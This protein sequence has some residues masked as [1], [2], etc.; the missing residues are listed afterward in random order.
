[1]ICYKGHVRNENHVPTPVCAPEQ[2]TL[3]VILDRLGKVQALPAQAPLYWRALALLSRMALILADHSVSA[4]LLGHENADAYA[5]T[6]TGKM[7][8]RL[9]WHL[10]NVG[11]RAGDMVFNMLSL[12][13]P[14]LSRDAVERICR[15]ATGRYAWQEKAARCRSPPISTPALIWFSTWPAPVRAKPT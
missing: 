12:A 9:D 7:N 5:N 3:D 10:Q 2:L 15:R 11:Y 1:M 6:D 13:S 8:Q 14:S 4:E